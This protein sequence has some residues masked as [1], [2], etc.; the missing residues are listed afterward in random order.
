MYKII[1]SKSAEKKLSRLP[2]DVILK[3]SKEIDT[4][5]DNPRRINCKKLVGAKR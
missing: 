2:T 3:I 4:L 5:A 1:I